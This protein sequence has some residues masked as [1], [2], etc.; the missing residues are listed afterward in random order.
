[1][2]DSVSQGQFGVDVVGDYHCPA[3]LWDFV[4]T[5]CVS[6]WCLTALFMFNIVFALTPQLLQSG[7]FPMVSF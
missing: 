1:M 4:P 3:A 7:Y 5:F 6:K 2:H